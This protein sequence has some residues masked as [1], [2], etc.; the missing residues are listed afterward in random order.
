MLPT[1]CIVVVSVFN[2]NGT[3]KVVERQGFANAQAAQAFSY[4]AQNAHSESGAMVR[5]MCRVAPPAQSLTVT[6]R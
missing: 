6:R 2:P 4:V 3:T 1:F 5:V